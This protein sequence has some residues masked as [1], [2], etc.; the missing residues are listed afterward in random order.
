MIKFCLSDSPLLQERI[1]DL[2]KKFPNKSEVELKAELTAAANN[3]NTFEVPTMEQ[4]NAYYEAT[5]DLRN[6]VTQ[7]KGTSSGYT[8]EMRSIKREAL[9]DGTF[10]KAPNGNPTNLNERQWLQVRTKA[11]KDWFGDWER[12][13]K[14]YNRRTSKQATVRLNRVSGEKFNVNP[15]TMKGVILTDTN[16]HSIFKAMARTFILCN[17]NGNVIPFYQSSRGTSGKIKG[18]WYPFFGYTGNWLIKGD[19][20]EKGEMSYSSEIDRITNLLNKDFKIPT[21]FDNNGI[22][23]ST[24]L[25][26]RDLGLNV[27]TVFDRFRKSMSDVN[28]NDPTELVFYDKDLKESTNADALFVKEITGIKTEGIHQSHASQS[29]IKPFID[30]TNTGN[31]S[32]VVD[33]NGEPLVVYHASNKEFQIYRQSLSDYGFDSGIFFSSSINY[34]KKVTNADIKDAAFLNIKNPILAEDLERN[35]TANIFL[36]EEPVSPD[37]WIDRYGTYDGYEEY[38]KQKESRKHDGIIGSDKD[39]QTATGEYI[40]GEHSLEYVVINSNQIKSAEG[41]NGEF[42]GENDNIYQEGDRDL[43]NAPRR[44]S[45]LTELQRIQNEEGSIGVARLINLIDENSEFAPIIDLLKSRQNSGTP[46]LSGIKVQLYDTLVTPNRKAKFNGRRAYYDAATKTIVI[47]TNADYRD[48]R[49]DSVIMHEVMHAIT[50][51]RILNNTKFREEFDSIIDEYNKH[52]RNYRYRRPSNLG[53][54][55]YMEEFIADIWSNRTLIENL[56]AIPTKNKLTLWD[57]IKRFFT[58]IFRGADNTMLADASD[59]LYRL[60][61]EPEI[62]NGEDTYYEGEDNQPAQTINIWHGSGENADLSNLAVR[63]FTIK[64]VTFNTVEHFFQYTKAKFAKD[65]DIASK[66]IQA[67]TGYDARKLGRQVKGLDSNA[68]DAKSSE[69]M[70]TGIRASFLQNPQA[71]QKLRDTGNARLTHTQDTG[72]WGTEFPRIL[73]EVRDELTK[74]VPTETAQNSKQQSQKPKRITIQYT[75]VGKETQTYEVE[76]SHIYNKEGKEVFKEAS[77][78]RNK[79]FANVAV[80]EKRAVVVE[81][82]GTRYVVN[83]K[84][85]IMTTSKTNSGAI[86]Q[87]GPENGDR[88]AILAAARQ[89]FE[90]LRDNPTLNPISSLETRQALND[91]TEQQEQEVAQIA[92]L[93]NPKLDEAIDYSQLDE[94]SHMDFKSTQEREDRVVLLAHLFSNIVNILQEEEGNKTPRKQFI[95]ENLDTIVESIKEELN[96]DYVDDEYSKIAYTKILNNLT[97]LLQEAANILYFTEGVSITFNSAEVQQNEGEDT[98]LTLDASSDEYGEYSSKDGWM[99]RARELDLRDTLSQQTRKLLNTII[100]VGKDGSIETDDLGFPKYLDQDWAHLKLLETLSKVASSDEFDSTLEKMAKSQPWVNGVIEVL[101]D[102]PISKAKFYQDLRKEFV[103]YWIQMG[104]ITKEIN[105]DPSIYHLFNI[106]KYNIEQASKLSTGPSIYGPNGAINI[107]GGKEGVKGIEELLNNL[108][109]VN[110]LDPE[111]SQKERADYILKQSGKIAELLGRTGIEVTDEDVETALE[112]SGELDDL[113]ERG[114]LSREETIINNFSDIVGQLNVI[115]RGVATDNIKEDT[116]LLEYFKSAY[117]TL[118][119]HLNILPQG[120]TIASFREAGKSYQSYSAPSYLGRFLNALKTNKAEEYLQRE[121]GNYKYFYRN[122]KYTIDWLRKLT[123][124]Q[125]YRNL[126]GRKVVL[127]RDRKEFNEWSP[128]TYQQVMFD[129]YFSDPSTTSSG[130]KVGWYY[131]PLLADAPS[132]EFIRFVRYTDSSEFGANGK[133]KSMEDLIIPKLADVVEQELHRI[134]VVSARQQGIKDGRIQPITGFDNPNKLFCFFPALNTW[135]DPETKQSFLEI[136]YDKKAVDPVEAR[137]FIEEVVRNLEEQEFEKFR[138][139]TAIQPREGHTEPSDFNADLKEFFYNSALAYTQIVQLTTTD[140]AYYKDLNDFQKRYKEVYAMT[141]RLYLNS[142]RGKQAENIVMLKD[143]NIVS[144]VLTEIREVLDKAV[145][146]GRITKLERDYIANQFKTINVTDAQ[147]FRSLESYRAIMDMSGNWTQE[148]EDAYNRLNSDQWQAEDFQVLWETIKPFVFTQY[149]IDSGITTQEGNPYGDLKVPMQIKNSEFLL[150]ALYNSI[151]KHQSKSNLL[152]AMNDFMDGYSLDENGNKVKTHEPVDLIQ[153]ESGIKVGGQGAINLN[154]LS[155]YEDFLKNL[156]DTAFPE[157]TLNPQVVKTISFEDYGIQQPSPEHLLDHIDMMGSQFRRLI[158][159]DLPDDFQVT[160]DGKQYNKV[161]IH[162]LY[163][164]ILTENIL[165]SFKKVSDKFSSAEKIE[166]A[167]QREMA[168]NTRYTDED[169][170]ACTLIERNGTKVFQ[171]PLY[172]PVQSLRMQQLL[173]SIIKKEITKQSSRRASA[174]QVSS[175]GLTDE[176]QIRYQDSEGNLIFSEREWDGNFDKA[177]LSRKDV[178]RLERLKK[179]F[180]TY[181]AYRN[182]VKASSQQ[183]WECYLPAYSRKFFEPFMEKNA[184]G[185]ATGML[186][187]SKLPNN[188]RKAIG[189]RIPTEAKYSMQALYIKGFLPQNNGSAIMLPAEITQ[190]TGSD[191][192]IDKVYILLPEFR[193]AIDKTDYNNLSDKEKQQWEDLGANDALL[194]TIFGDAF[195]VD[196]SKNSGFK[197]WLNYQKDNN[198]EYYQSL[199][200]NTIPL[201][202]KYDY[203]KPAKEQ[204]REARNNAIIDIAHAI[205]TSPYVSE[206]VHKSGGF[207]IATHVSNIVQA[208]KNIPTKDLSQVTGATTYE[209]IVE[210]LNKMEDDDLKK[211]LKSFTVPL[212]P[213]TPATQS[214]FHD[215]NANGGKMIGVYAVGNA[216]HVSA[217]WSKSYTKLPFTLFGGSFY[218]VLDNMYSKDG[219]LISE[220]IANFLA[221]SVDNVKSPVLKT[222]NQDGTTGDVTNFLLRAGVSI[223]DVGIFLNMPNYGVGT[224]EGTVNDL[225]LGEAAKAISLA[226]RDNLTPEEHSYLMMLDASSE[227]DPASA[228]LY[229]SLVEKSNLSIENR[230]LLNTIMLRGN[231]KLKEISVLSR[232]LSEITRNARGDALSS[233]AG[234]YLANNILRYLQLVKLAERLSINPTREK[235][236][237]ISTNI[238]NLPLILNRNNYNIDAIREGSMNSG[239]PFIQAATKCGVVGTLDLMGKLFPQMKD[240]ILPLLTD[241]DRGLSYFV[242][243]TKMKEETAIK[244]IN[245]F[246][247]EFYLYVLSSKNFFGGKTLGEKKANLEYQREGFLQDFMRLK[248][249]NPELKNNRFIQSLWVNKGKKRIEFKDSKDLSRR[250]KAIL[251]NDW[252]SLLV[253]K[254]KEVSNLAFLLFRHA[255]LNG[256]TYMGPQ[257]YIQLAPQVLKRAIPDYM[258]TMDELMNS[259]GLQYWEF[260][261]QFVRN[262]LEEPGFCKLVLDKDIKKTLENGDIVIG[263]VRKFINIYNADTKTTTPYALVGKDA[264]EGLNVYTKITRLG[265][266]GTFKEY[267]FGEQ[268]PESIVAQTVTPVKMSTSADYYLDADTAPMFSEEDIQAIEDF[269]KEEGAPVPTDSEFMFERLE[270][271]D[272]VT[273]QPICG[274]PFTL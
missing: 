235:P 174:I 229:T 55:H 217:E 187:I 84:D 266:A 247:D 102:D 51:N 77:R 16:G 196:D 168:G 231:A 166:E 163:Q 184:A 256:L 75:P 171:I 135:E 170:K 88:K 155:S 233:A 117:T 125:E 19:V 259:N 54:T 39:K 253:S 222:L 104:G 139:E 173:N 224:I 23:N 129:E 95:V 161:E 213:L 162:K 195:D 61:D 58:K 274:S 37:D 2:Q 110:E 221:A 24:G 178:A 18:N 251:T 108:P 64:G 172:D 191:F 40:A 115:F 63:P 26:V 78:D 25:N 120:V 56:K 268:V 128:E 214:F 121:F 185:E 34:A 270:A 145:T 134:S 100:K 92:K 44:D 38:I 148:M 7:N 215:Q 35:K 50:V 112:T 1:R 244:L 186:D 90:A 159:S 15:E 101:K 176:L 67:K 86:M 200:K 180:K 164:S 216:S 4:M 203:S 29:F 226:A 240:N 114:P 30:A 238:L 70:E 261:N 131:L 66:I 105:R 3:L 83:D 271:I 91:I 87:W 189:Y 79:I 111:E 8:D 149:S 209:T 42:S 202:I 46:L 241:K 269:E 169:R 249:E 255:A 179:S 118:A 245:R 199:T 122:G 188:L 14:P 158:D 68:W 236:S 263:E 49:A 154:G 53:N 28:T 96:P 62:I 136:Y 265:V 252:A 243:L 94:I 219:D 89:K 10:M 210:A 81:H 273:G 107:E 119:S 97:I 156:N 198:P 20:N 69:F 165:D 59:A 230:R 212:N 220:N 137:D 177:E 193:F 45:R 207:E 17:V 153:F 144:T 151:A 206:Q 5:K 258:E 85:V 201:K 12:V 123:E 116:S 257:S 264:E 43:G 21:D 232:D 32:K 228:E 234:P 181:K 167:L 262:H 103:P 52:F 142:P 41:N 218:Q 130:D 225:K 197:A 109:E 138:V 60:L 22:S 150:L 183:Y 272:P 93:G 9:K 80:R 76:G 254:D 124:S 260:V 98:S 143:F 31:V 57:R 6:P 246:F 157:N 250:E 133:Y 152:R 194:S 132:A 65:D 208:L 267:Y 11:F 47:D 248:N 182:S 175:V 140:L 205:L 106:W 82:R 33:E 99:I 27:Y 48:G 113:L 192:D 211:L 13:A 73:M 74:L 223:L 127:H 147:G 126:L 242:D 227:L 36:S 146:A 239:V 71:L 190:T 237:T 204:S 72:K 160:I 141:N